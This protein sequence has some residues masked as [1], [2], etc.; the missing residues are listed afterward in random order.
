MRI[1][2]GAFR[3]RRLFTPKGDRIRPTTDRVRE[4]IFSIIAPEVAGAAVLDLYA[5]TGAMGLEALSRG[6]GRAVFVDQSADAVRIIR[7]NIEL[8]GAADRARIIR[9]GA[10]AA[11]RRLAA[12]GEL[13]GL[14]F[15]DPPYGKGFIE[16]TIAHLGDIASGSSLAVA[17][18]HIKDVSPARCGGWVKT[19]ERRYGDT[20]ISFYARESLERDFA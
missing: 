1:V 10:P 3:G 2:A 7:A 11:I 17:E 19:Q 16:K 6:A 13:F 9:S 5:G 4:A 15:L 8:C 20:L 18:H 14:V 12:G